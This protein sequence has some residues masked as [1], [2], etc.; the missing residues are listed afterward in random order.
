VLEHARGNDESKKR[1]YRETQ[2]HGVWVLE[3]QKRGRVVTSHSLL[4]RGEREGQKGKNIT[5]TVPTSGVRTRFKRLVAFI[6][7]P[8]K[9]NA[10][11]SGDIRKEPPNVLHTLKVKIFADTYLRRDI[12]ECMQSTAVGGDSTQKSNIW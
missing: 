8:S 4:T 3:A 9:I 5:C 7:G 11:K 1:K 2:G 6:E 12:R 10:T